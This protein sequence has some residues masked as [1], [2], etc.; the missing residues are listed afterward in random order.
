LNRTERKGKKTKSKKRLMQT[1]AVYH[2]VG[3]LMELFKSSLLRP[4]NKAVAGSRPKED[5]TAARSF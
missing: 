4:A 3:K 5:I 1:V 2:G